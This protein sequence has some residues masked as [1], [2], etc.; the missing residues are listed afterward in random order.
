M[1]DIAII[2]VNVSR[3]ILALVKKKNIYEILFVNLH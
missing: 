3:G 2:T 1:V